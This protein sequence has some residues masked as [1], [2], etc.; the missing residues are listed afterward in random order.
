MVRSLI[1]SSQIL[2]ICSKQILVM[3]D[4]QSSRITPQNLKA[5]QLYQFFLKNCL[6]QLK[7]HNDIKLYILLSCYLI[8]KCFRTFEQTSLVFYIFQHQL[9]AND[10]QFQVLYFL[11]KQ[12]QSQDSVKELLK[13]D[14]YIPALILSIVSGNN[15]YKLCYILIQQQNQM[16][17]KIL[18]SFSILS[19]AKA[20]FIIEKVL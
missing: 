18:V 9:R 13:Q 4:T 7:K 3:K 12:Q 2:L 16:K 10:F 5:V 14:F 6:N 1:Y 15:S 11:S 20:R 17:L 19:K 8:N